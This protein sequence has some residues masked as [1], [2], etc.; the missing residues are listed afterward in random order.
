[1]STVAWV[2]NPEWTFD[3]GPE[4]AVTVRAGADHV[5]VLD[6]LPAGVAAEVAACW[7]GVVARDGLSAGA[8]GPDTLSP[9]AARAVDQLVLLGALRP[10]VAAAGP[11]LAVGVTFAGTIPPALQDSLAEAVGAAGCARQAVGAR[12]DLAVCVRT[13]ATLADA[14]T[15]AAGLTMPHL[16]VDA[17]HHH[18]VSLGPLVVPGETACLGCLAG[19]IAARWGDSSPPPAPAAAGHAVLVAG[20][21]AVELAKVAVG[22]CELANRTVALDLARWRVTDETLLRLPGCPGC[23]ADQDGRR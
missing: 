9:G 11:T 20:L 2:A 6:D 13:T 17:A 22:T 12:A 16:F 1:M 19:R 15:Q 21:V 18:T 8:V 7:A 4:E 10:A 14:A 5:F 23:G 3:E